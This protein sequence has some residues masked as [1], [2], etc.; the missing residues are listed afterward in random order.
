MAAGLWGG[1]PGRGQPGQHKAGRQQ[2]SRGGQR[3]AAN[4]PARMA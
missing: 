3:L 2:N 1:K 4:P